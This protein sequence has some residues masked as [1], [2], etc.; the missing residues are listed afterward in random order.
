MP[1]VGA[2]PFAVSFHVVS[3]SLLLSSSFSSLFS[4][5][6]SFCAFS[7]LF[8][9]SLPSDDVDGVNASFTLPIC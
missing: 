5:S 4:V 9:F 8:A 2:Y 6:S 3:S 7:M 1:M